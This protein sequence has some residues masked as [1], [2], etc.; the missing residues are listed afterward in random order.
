MS[1]EFP[2]TLRQ[3]FIDD[4]LTLSIAIGSTTFVLGAWAVQE[5]PPSLEVE[6]KAP[7]MGLP[8]CEFEMHSAICLMLR[9]R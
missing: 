1:F 9:P 2:E 5:L 4:Q 7:S 6:I 8:D 3:A